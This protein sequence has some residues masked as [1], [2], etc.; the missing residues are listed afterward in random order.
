MDID[1]RET[2]SGRLVDK[3]SCLV[4]TPLDVT[5]AADHNFELGKLRPCVSSDQR[6]QASTMLSNRG[7]F[8]RVL[9]DVA[10]SRNDQPSPPGCIR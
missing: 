2:S 3:W 5:P 9:L 7:Y 10:I 1:G 6:D 8:P 4:K